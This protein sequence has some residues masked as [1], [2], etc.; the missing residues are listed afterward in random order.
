MQKK[1]LHF[2]DVVPVNNKIIYAPFFMFYFRKEK[3]SVHFLLWMF[4]AF[5]GELN[6]NSEH[7]IISMMTQNKLHI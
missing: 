2:S 7:W 5:K 6:K 1:W 4:W 3:S